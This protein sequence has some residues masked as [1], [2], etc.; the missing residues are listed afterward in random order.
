MSTTS[1]AGLPAGADLL[2]TVLLL[3]ALLG[4]ALWAFR[5]A[6]RSGPLWRATPRRLQ[7]IE[8]RALGPRHRVALVRVDDREVL[9]GVSPAQIS[10][11]DRWPSTPQEPRRPTD[12]ARPPADGS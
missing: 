9:I 2:L 11:L 6:L 1:T 12:T 4:A 5:R 10:M 8:V 3:L 7:L